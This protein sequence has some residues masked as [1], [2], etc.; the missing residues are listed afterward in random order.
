MPG[1]TPGNTGPAS[2]FAD[3]KSPD[4]DEGEYCLT[5]LHE[6]TAAADTPIINLVKLARA[7]TKVLCFSNE[8][9][10]LPLIAPSAKRGHN[11][12]GSFCTDNLSLNTA[13]YV[14]LA[15]LF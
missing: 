5:T 3:L 8:R 2:A 7:A 11:F 4:L 1:F 14:V 13:C 12:R 6:A 15:S 9:I 10:S